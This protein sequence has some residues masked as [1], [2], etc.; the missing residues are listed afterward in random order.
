MDQETLRLEFAK[1]ADQRIDPGHLVVSRYPQIVK[2]VLGSCVSIV[3]YHPRTRLCGISHALLPSSNYPQ[4]SC[5]DCVAHC[6]RGLGKERFR[7]VDCSTRYLYSQFRNLKIPRKE[8]VIKLFGG[9]KALKHVERNI[10]E[11][12]VAMA[13]LVLRE[14]GLSIDAEET[15]GTQGCTIRVNSDSGEV[16]LR[17]HH[18]KMSD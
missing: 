14:L 3:M 8:I 11:E 1:A 18:K 15:G 6:K 5:E 10:G 7:Y 13:H 2:T 17:R 16:I 9:A 4:K 12:N